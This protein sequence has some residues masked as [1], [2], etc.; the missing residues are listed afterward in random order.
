MDAPGLTVRPF[1]QITGS[2]EF[3]EVF[4]DDVRIPV[5]H[6]VGEEGDGW[7]IAMSTV[8]FERGPADVGYIADLQRNVQALI[9]RGRQGQ[10]GA[11]PA[12]LRR[13]ARS[14]VDVQVLRAQVLR[15]VA[16]QVK[17]QASEAEVSVDKLL[18]VRAEQAFGHTTMDLLG[19]GP[20]AGTQPDALHQYLWSRAASVYGG[21]QEIQ[22][23]II[24][25]RLLGLPRG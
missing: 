4:F 6:R 14:Y 7:R 8:A 10:L 11:D 1:R 12:L 19:A 21:S 18:M 13:L 22:R 16:R 5:D 3:A 15:T 17:G 25:T 23:T 2:L 24:A 9:D 20:V